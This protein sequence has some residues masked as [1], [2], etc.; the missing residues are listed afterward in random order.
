[1]RTPPSE[2]PPIPEGWT[3]IGNEAEINIDGCE[4]DFARGLL[5]GTNL[6][7][8]GE[9]AL[10]TMRMWYNGMYEP[11]PRWHY[12]AVNGS[13]LARLNS[14]TCPCGGT[15][16]GDAAGGNE[17]LDDRIGEM[18][19]TIDRLHSD[20]KERAGI[21]YSL[22]EGR[23]KLIGEKSLLATQVLDMKDAVDRWQAAHH[24]AATRADKLEREKRALRESL[25]RGLDLLTKYLGG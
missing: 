19:A 10:I 4:D 9:S 12:I 5:F 20:V 6:E 7:S 17:D 16:V 21:I 13:R 25:K 1:M 8:W 24:D 18:R 2:L 14:D 3:Y 22:L 23:D 11:Q 15:M